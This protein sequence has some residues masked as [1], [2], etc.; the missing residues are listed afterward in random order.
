MNNL[1]RIG[2]SDQF[3]LV[4]EIEPIEAGS[5]LTEIYDSLLSESD[6]L[7]KHKAVEHRYHKRFQLKE[8]TFALIRAVSADPLKIHGKSMGG[9]ACAV[10]NARPARLGKIDNI[11][12]GGLMFQHV[13]NKAQSNQ[14][15]VLDI[16]R[17]DCGFY[18]ANI[19]FTTKSDVVIPDEISGATIEMRQVRLQYQSLNAIQ[20]AK[21]KNFIMNHATDTAGPVTAD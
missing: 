2:N 21:L 19:L 1:Y 8:G 15:F 5:N 6:V 18:I 12:M 14:E 16:L 11:S 7:D 3:Q 10:Y 4:D 17:V 13:D 20:H 9:I